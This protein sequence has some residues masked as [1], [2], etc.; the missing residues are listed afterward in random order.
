VRLKGYQKTYLAACD[1]AKDEGI[2]LPLVECEWG[3]ALGIES[4]SLAL[5]GAPDSEQLRKAAEA[6]QEWEYLD[7]DPLFE[8]RLLTIDSST[9]A[10]AARFG[11]R[12]RH[13][14]F[15]DTIEA[16]QASLE[17][18]ALLKRVNAWE[19]WL[20]AWN[21]VVTASPVAKR[22]VYASHD[23]IADAAMALAR[24][25]VAELNVQVQ[26]QGLPALGAAFRNRCVDRLRVDW[27]LQVFALRGKVK[28]F[29]TGL[30]RRRRRE[31]SDRLWPALGDILLYQANGDDILE[32]IRG[33]VK[34][35][36]PPVYL[37]AH[38]LGGI[39]CVDLLVEA[40]PSNVAGLITVGS[41]SPLLYELGALRSLKRGQPLPDAFPRWINLYDPN[42]MLSYVAE[43]LFP[44]RVKDVEVQSGE[45]PLAA[46]SA[47]WNCDE[48]W[49]AIKD[50]ITT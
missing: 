45:L 7:A 38:S 13:E 50:F 8:L 15:W 16:Y 36:R 9:T 28:A 6:E 44:G 34:P 22:A 4:P 40:P 49:T 30:V 1:R 3:D 43:K 11:G 35:L 21:T 26:G 42:D 20:D 17:L 48:T 24:A 39:A 23:A 10:P 14:K 31:W 47:Y 32:F 41:Q 27:G 37:L 2:T 29:F 19:Q 33:K 18:E 12:P 5:P 46:H 25:L